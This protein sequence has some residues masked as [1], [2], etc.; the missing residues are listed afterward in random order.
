MKT[1][2]MVTTQGYTKFAL[3]AFALTAQM[4]SSLP[5]LK[6]IKIN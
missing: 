1:K 6:A 2:K 3:F 4:R 5:P